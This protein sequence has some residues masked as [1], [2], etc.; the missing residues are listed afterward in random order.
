MDITEAVF[1]QADEIGPEKIVYLYEPKTRMK[2]IVVIDNVAAGPAIGGVRMAP[3]VTADEVRRLARAMTYKNA[4]A[5]LPHG[6]GK[7]GIIADPKTVDKEQVIRI[8]ARAIKYL[9]EYIP[10]PDIGTDETCMAYILDENSR[11]VGLP[12]ELGGIPLDEIG[13][14]SYGVALC[15]EV[16]KDYIKLDLHGARLTIEG[17]GNVGKPAARFL[18]ERGAILIAASDSKGTIYNPAGLNVEVLIRIKETTGSVINYKDGEVLK[19]TDLITISTDIFIPAAR[20]DVITEA[21]ADVLDA[22]LVIEGANIPISENAEKML[23]DR[24]ILVIPD[25]VANAGG[26]ITASVEYHGGTEATAFEKIKSTIPRNTKEILY[27][28]YHEKM[29]PREAALAIAK[30]RVLHMMKYRK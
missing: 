29:Y 8:F 19:T 5:D 30:R 4:M 20:P 10:G 16:A 26:V 21:N 24:G 25:F 15:A 14:T 27:K 11:S 6:G 12:R 9:E 13:A 1:E 2:A 18:A 23:H 22:K 7:S 3:D 28:V 17:F